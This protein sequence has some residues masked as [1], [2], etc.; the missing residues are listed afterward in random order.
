MKGTG[1]K[2]QKTAKRTIFLTSQKGVRYKQYWTIQ[3]MRERAVFH[4]HQTAEM[5]GA[6]RI[7]DEWLKEYQTPTEK[8]RREQEKEWKEHHKQ[9]QSA[10]NRHA[11]GKQPSAEELKRARDDLNVGKECL[12]KCLQ[13]YAMSSSSSSSLD[14]AFPI[15]AFTALFGGPGLH[16]YGRHTINNATSLIV[17][18]GAQGLEELI[19]RKSVA[20]GSDVVTVHVNFDREREVV[21]QFQVAYDKNRTTLE[22]LWNNTKRKDSP[23]GNESNETLI[24]ENCEE[25][26]WTCGTCTF[27]H[28]GEVK[29]LFLTCEMCGACRQADTRSN[30]DTIPNTSKKETPAASGPVRKRIQE[31]L[32]S[33]I[34]CPPSAKQGWGSLR[35]PLDLDIRGSQKRRKALDKTPPMMDFIIVLDFEWT[36]DNRR[37]MEPIAEITQFPSVAMKLFKRRDENN[38]SSSPLL[39]HKSP[40][41]LPLDLT[42]PLFP[43]PTQDMCAISAFDTFVQP[44]LNPR[45]TN[46]SMELTEITQ[47][48]V[49]NAPRIATALQLYMQWLESLQLVDPDGNRQGN[50]CFATWGDVDIMQTLR[51]ELQYKSIPLPKCFDRWINLKDDSI[52]KKHYGREPR[53]GLRTCVESVHATWE[54]RAHNGLVDSFNT[55]KIVRHMVQTGFHFTRATRGLNKDG[56]PFGQVD[57]NKNGNVRRQQKPQPQLNT[58][59]SNCL[60]RNELV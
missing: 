25:V 42:I 18:D 30:D 11:Y 32:P 52:F 50:W 28:T 26:S 60:P 59:T 55:A 35:A 40:V 20:H 41:L 49:D 54:G 44:T 56:V 24:K 5:R 46:F 39:E 10:A 1:F 15:V 21:T 33:S 38:K 47:Q 17:I 14:E 23:H 13:K 29:L 8:E 3:A 16:G 34:S 58:E 19:S 2:D 27:Q 4:P 12:Q 43:T 51:Q 48:D 22:S 31:R 7:F 53:G 36:A 45:L 6:I 57:N 37:K 9:C